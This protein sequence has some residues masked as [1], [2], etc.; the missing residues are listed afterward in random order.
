MWNNKRRK[1]Y[2]YGYQN[3]CILE[4]TSDEE[5]ETHRSKTKVNESESMK[6]E[7]SVSRSSSGIGTSSRPSSKRRDFSDETS[8]RCFSPPLQNDFIE[9]ESDKHK[10]ETGSHNKLQTKKNVNNILENKNST[11]RSLKKSL[12]RR[13]NKDKL[14]TSKDKDIHDRYNL[15][16]NTPILDKY[17]PKNLRDNADEDFGSYSEEDE[18]FSISDFE[19]NVEVNDQYSKIQKIKVH[20]KKST[21]I[22]NENYRSNLQLNEETKE[23]KKWTKGKDI[24]QPINSNHDQ[25]LKKYRGNIRHSS[26]DDSDSE[27]E[28]EEINGPRKERIYSDQLREC[29]DYTSNDELL[30]DKPAMNTL[31][32]T[33]SNMLSKIPVFTR[34][35]ADSS[36]ISDN[37][38]VLSRNS[39]PWD[40]TS[41]IDRALYGHRKDKET[42]NLG[43]TNSTASVNIKRSGK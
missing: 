17:D 40:T 26:E 18:S 34:Q 36:S 19:E 14:N 5:L 43:R 24:H 23:T 39:K 38:S 12:S 1:K 33:F 7:K 28:E 8:S 11:L 27:N 4:E 2:G 32:K 25:Y 3:D 41:T 42:R 29:S 9:E 10:P 37:C 35:H 22:N 31:K 30:N 15:A 16:Q 6:K 20:K 21:E 13:K